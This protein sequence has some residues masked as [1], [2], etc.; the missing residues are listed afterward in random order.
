[1]VRS[2]CVVGSAMGY[3]TNPA[4][5]VQWSALGLV[6]PHCA[7]LLVR[8]LGAASIERVSRL[9]MRTLASAFVVLSG[10]AALATVRVGITQGACTPR[11]GL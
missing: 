8:A 1:M 9:C 10:F 6:C 5:C 7:R 11:L 4:P 3:V 2:C